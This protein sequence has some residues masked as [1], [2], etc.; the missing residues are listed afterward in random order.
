MA[1]ECVSCKA[2]LTAETVALFEVV[3]LCPECNKRAMQAKADCTRLL[4]G[5]SRDLGKLLVLAILSVG[6]PE[7]SDEASLFTFL[8]A[9]LTE[10][11]QRAMHLEVQP[12]KD[13]SC[14]LPQT[15]I[16]TKTL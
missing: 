7:K 6:L 1:I 2:P 4:S 5:V 11:K 12:S 10:F 13:T 16:P 8:L 14:L 3:L 9:A 15:T